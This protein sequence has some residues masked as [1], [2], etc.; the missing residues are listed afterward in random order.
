MATLFIGMP[1]FGMDR[2]IEEALDSL[3]GQDFENWQLLIA[4]NHSSD[5][6]PEIGKRY[7]QIDSRI[8]F[9]R[10]D[11]NL[12]APANFKYVL[13][14]ADGDY[15][16]WAAGDDVWAPGYISFGI[17][18]LE[19]DDRVGLAFGN[20]VN[21]DTY[22]HI[23]RTYPGF[24]AFSGPTQWRN[25]LRYQLSPEIMGK[26]NLIYGVMP[27]DRARAAKLAS[28][29]TDN[30]GSDMAFVLAVI[31]RSRF[32]YIE[33]MM[34]EKRVVRDGDVRGKPRPIVISRPKDHCFEIAVAPTYIAEAL[35]A[36]RGTPFLLLTVITMG[37]RLIS[38]CTRKFIARAGHYLRLFLARKS[39][40]R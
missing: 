10:H 4:D 23:I 27:L 37:W 30:W 22:G 1:V 31:S 15:F 35:G 24:A 19:A 20:V 28:P 16:M 40:R 2:F 7:E 9:V 29:L 32:A 8:R 33:S 25:I 39:P 26:A 5:R 21:T 13:D 11:R 3:I 12:G 6:T 18:A 14:A 17:A 36:V 34:L 38:V